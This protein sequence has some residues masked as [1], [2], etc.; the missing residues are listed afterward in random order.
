MSIKEK[1]FKLLIID[2]EVEMLQAIIAQAK[3]LGYVQIYSADN[4]DRA[5]SL[6]QNTKI[7]GILA[8]VNMPQKDLLNQTL[9]R[10]GIPVA[11]V[12]G[13]SQRV[14]NFMLNKPFSIQKLASV[15]TQL[16][17]LSDAYQEAA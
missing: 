2:D 11:R 9:S 16:R 17:M 15:L 12:S 14:V 10:C 8:D 3:V 1:D 4:V 5:L 13:E 6:I 7:D